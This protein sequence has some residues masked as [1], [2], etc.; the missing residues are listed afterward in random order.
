MLHKSVQLQ[1]GVSEI[2]FAL[3]NRLKIIIES[4]IKKVVVSMFEENT[5]KKP[6]TSPTLQFL[7]H[8]GNVN[9]MVHFRFSW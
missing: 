1:T 4:L 7:D 3:M 6:M 8:T 9:L 5:F 2:Q